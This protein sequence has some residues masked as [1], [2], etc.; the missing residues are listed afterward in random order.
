M[1]GIKGRKMK[2][3][4]I[5]VVLIVGMILSLAA[6]KKNKEEIP[7]KNHSLTVESEDIEYSDE[8]INEL[9]ARIADIS[10]R[11]VP[12]TGDSS[13]AEET[14]TAR[15]EFIKSNVF[16]LFE[17]TQVYPNELYA[18]VESVEHLAV[19]GAEEQ[20]NAYIAIGMY[21]RFNAVLGAERLASLVYEMLLLRIDHAVRQIGRAHV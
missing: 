17:K 7:E 18:L 10:E 6:C 13:L 12:I 15:I 2:K 11:F 19:Y 1:N 20:S 16:P 9:A 8:A 5:S 3:R 14:K 4:I 21:Q